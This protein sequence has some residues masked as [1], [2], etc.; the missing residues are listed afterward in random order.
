MDI[1]AIQERIRELL[2]IFS[3]R[4]KQENISDRYDINRISESIMVP[5]LR[6][7]YDYKKLR[8]LNYSDELNYPGIDIADDE[9]KIAFQITST[10][11][12]QKVKHTLEQ[13]KKHKLDKK[14]NRFIVYILTSKKGKYSDKDYAMMDVEFHKDR[15]IWDYLD[16]SKRVSQIDDVATLRKIL[17]Y[18]EDAIGRGQPFRHRPIETKTE[19]LELNFVEIDVPKEIFFAE[20]DIDRSLLVEKIQERK[21]KPHYKISDRDIICEF[22]SQNLYKYPKD[23]VCYEKNIIT[24]HDLTNDEHPYYAVID[25]ITIKKVETNSFFED[26]NGFDE[27][28]ERVLKDLLRRS[29]VRILVPYGIQWHDLEKL[30]FFNFDA[31]SEDYSVVHNSDYNRYERKIRWKEKKS[32][33]RVVSFRRYPKDLPDETYYYFHLAFKVKFNLIDDRWY[34]EITPDWHASKDGYTNSYFRKG[35]KYRI[36][37]LS[38][39]VKEKKEEEAN[40]VVF[41]HFRFIRTFFRSIKSPLFNQSFIKF[42]RDLRFHSSPILEDK[43]WNP[44]FV[45]VDEDEQ[46]DGSNKPKRKRGRRR[47]KSDINLENNKKDFN[48]NTLF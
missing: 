8:N 29:L 33:E 38:E 24:F 1:G 41:N 5:V 17:Q 44:D 34:L 42:G 3:R 20:I 21:Y 12:N 36:L 28:R 23:F 14:Y 26:E 7:L 39:K 15:D 47:K 4:I 32:D 30:F 13:I 40:Q 6:L 45:Y 48:Q 37:Y 25:P 16:L 31:D 27:G 19:E 43:L 2:E 10:S 11:D 18:L 46:T 22:F 35:R 9:A